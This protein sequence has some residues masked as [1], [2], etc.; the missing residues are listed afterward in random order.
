MR[1]S[2]PAA[3]ADY[4]A[5]GKTGE[6]QLR[7]GGGFWGRGHPTFVVMSERLAGQ[8]GAGRACDVEAAAGPTGR[9][10]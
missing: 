4:E 10:A 6:A 1:A 3:N 8:A 9:G 5:V 2:H 7:R